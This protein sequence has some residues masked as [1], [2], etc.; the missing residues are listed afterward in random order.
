MCRCASTRELRTTGLTSSTATAHFLVFPFS[1]RRQRS[2]P[3]AKNSTTAATPWASR[4]ST[5]SSAARPARMAAQ[6]PRSCW[7]WSGRRATSP[8]SRAL[9]SCSSRPWSTPTR[10]RRNP[11]RRSSLASGQRHGR[12]CAWAPCRCGSALPQQTLLLPRRKLCVIANKDT[13]Q[14]CKVFNGHA[15]NPAA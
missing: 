5:T 3:A 7:M 9:A 15:D 8:R 14:G 4:T 1:Q 2:G 13:V 6:R 12:W 11:L 10:S